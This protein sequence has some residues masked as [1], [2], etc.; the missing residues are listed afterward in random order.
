MLSIFLLIAI[1][2]IFD[3]NGSSDYLFFVLNVK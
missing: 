2:G 3:I 1:N